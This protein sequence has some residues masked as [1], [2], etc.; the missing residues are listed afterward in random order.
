MMFAHHA[1]GQHDRVVD[2]GSAVDEDPVA[3]HLD[4][5]ED[6]ERVLLVEPRSTA[7]G[8]RG[9]ASGRDALSR[10]RKISPGVSIGIEK[11]ERVLGRCVRRQRVA[12]VHGDLVGERRQ[13]GEDA[14]AADDDAVLGVADLVQRHRVAGEDVVGRPVDRRVDD[15]CG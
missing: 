4:V 6:H 7:G 12:G 8:R 5:V 14:R 3:R 1:V 13:R 15:A 2:V 11:L 10:H 9:S